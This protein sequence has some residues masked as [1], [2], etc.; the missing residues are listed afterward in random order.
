MFARRG[1]CRFRV[2]FRPHLHRRNETAERRACA[3]QEIR[4]PP[5]VGIS[6]IVKAEQCR[7]T[8]VAPVSIFKNAT[9]RSLT[10]RA[11]RNFAS[12]TET[13]ATLVLRGILITR[14]CAACFRLVSSRIFF[15]SR[16]CKGVRRRL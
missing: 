13:G 4:P 6:G 12:E 2:A 1:V 10:L 16:K 3:G 9:Q 7:R 14:L 5:V 15:R 11:A 8:G